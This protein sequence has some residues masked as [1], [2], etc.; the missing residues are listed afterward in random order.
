M[1]KRKTGRIIVFIVYILTL[2]LMIADLV[3]N[4]SC[5]FLF[6]IMTNAILLFRVFGVH[7]FTRFLHVLLFII[8]IGALIYFTISENLVF[9]FLAII[10]IIQFLFSLHFVLFRPGF[11]IEQRARRVG[12]H[13]FLGLLVVVSFFWIISILL[14]NNWGVF[15]EMIYVL[16]FLFI[17]MTPQ[18]MSAKQAVVL[19]IKDRSRRST[20]ASVHSV[21]GR[22]SRGSQRGD[23]R[24]SSK[25]CRR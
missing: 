10:V 4:F 16:L 6:Y 7:W 19:A 18:F 11:T 8:L 24:R 1:A 17:V 20:S 13:A 3:L 23:S 14:P 25:E 15:L 9:A 5:I 2:I 21:D 12:W 22:T